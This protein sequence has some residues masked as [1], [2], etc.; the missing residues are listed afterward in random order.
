[1]VCGYQFSCDLLYGQEMLVEILT[2]II[3]LA[4]IYNVAAV[5]YGK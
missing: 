4:F 3:G 1:M 5:S 2:M